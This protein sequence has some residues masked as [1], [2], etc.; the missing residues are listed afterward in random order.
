MSLEYKYTCFLYKKNAIKDYADC[1]NNLENRIKVCMILFPRGRSFAGSNK[2]TAPLCPPIM[3]TFDHFH[4]FHTCIFSREKI[5]NIQLKSK[6]KKK[7]HR[8]KRWEK[9]CSF[10]R[11]LLKLFNGGRVTLGIF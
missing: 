1:A 2:T 7:Y 8:K 11:Q 9:E 4:F 6:K 5:I 3:L 10:I